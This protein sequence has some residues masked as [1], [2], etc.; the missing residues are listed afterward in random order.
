MEYVLSTLLLLINWTAN[1]SL[2]K[3]S[4]GFSLLTFTA[5]VVLIVGIILGSIQFSYMWFV[6][7]VILT[8]VILQNVM[9]RIMNRATSKFEILE[10]IIFGLGCSLV[11][12]QVNLQYAFI[13]YLSCIICIILVSYQTQ[14]RDA[15]RAEFVPLIINNHNIKEQLK[16]ILYLFKLYVSVFIIS[17]VVGYLLFT[18]VISAQ[19]GGFK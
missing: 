15:K 4:L 12:K 1:V 8:W 11:S 18:Y 16:R 17:L 7:F 14:L 2:R 5:I 19:V 6:I 3:N 9:E 10:L 13:H